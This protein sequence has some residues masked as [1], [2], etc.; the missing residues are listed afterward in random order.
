[1]ATFREWIHRLR[2]ALGRGRRDSDLEQELRLHA[3]MAAED[4][5]RRGDAP[6]AARFRTG[7]ASQAMDALRDQRGL[8][9]LDALASDIVFGWRQLNKHRT[10]S[11]AA[12]LSLGLAIGAT[13]AAF[14]LVDAVLLRPLPVTD[15]ANLF[16]VATTFV[17]SDGGSDYRD[18][19]DYPSFREYVKVAG[20][21]ADLMVVGS[22]ARQPAFFEGSGEPEIT[23]RQFLSGNVF[24][25][26]GLQPA[27][28][29]L[30]T[31]DDDRTPG[32]HPVAVLSHDFWT[33]RFGRDPA[34]LGKTF[35]A[36]NQQYE[37]VGVAAQGFTGTEPGRVAD[38]FLP[39][40]MNTEA[41]NSHGW[42]WFRMWLRPKPGVSPEQVRQ[43]LQARYS[44]FVRERLKNAPADAPKDRIDALLREEVRLLP[45]GAGASATQK[46][47]RM[48]LFIL[49]TLA[50]LLLLVACANVANLQTAQAMARRREM[51]LRVSIGAARSRL[52]QLVLMES[53]LLAVFASCVG[54]L[55]AAWSAPLIVSMLGSPDQP[56][57]L[58]LDPDWR[59]AAFGIALTVT[60]TVLFGIAPALRASA[61]K[62]IG[63]LKGDSDPHAHRRLA[64][65]LIAV[66][67]AFCVFLVFV[68]GLFMTTLNRLANKPLGFAHQRLVL[69]LLEGSTKQPAE[70]WA[71]VMDHV[72]QIPG[73]EAVALA[74]W[75]PLTGNRWRGTVRVTERMAE[76]NA[77]YFLEVTPRYFEALR[78]RIIHGRDFRAGD[79]QPRI[80]EQKQPVAGVGIVNE[81][82]ARVYFGGQNPVGRRVSVFDRGAPMEI[83]GLVSDAAYSSVREPMRPTVYVPI[84]TRTNGTLFVRTAG[85]AMSLAATLRREVPKSRPGLRVRH[86]EP[87]TALVR[88]QMVRERLLATL[89][90]FFALVALLLA[91][92]GLYG[93]LNYAV[94]RQRREIGIRMAL[95]ARAADIVK[96]VTAT[97]F[98]I[99]SLGSLVGLA[100][101]L[102]FGRVIDALL[103]QIKATD[104]LAIAAPLLTL[105][106]AAALAAL[107]P[108]LRA[109]RIDPAQTLRME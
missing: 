58:I 21:S 75:A 20:E 22:T 104:P 77:P 71:Q 50:A 35:R 4:A 11:I 41:L 27:I 16:V 109:S 102:A 30:L 61:V 93:V 100:G 97:T 19:F 36:G 86:V 40:M 105:A 1:M 18:D 92:I 80:N 57:R 39:S 94:V 82:L 8:P 52:I 64:N 44:A 9:A 72:R 48:P 28:G 26:F 74:G 76:S 87:Q 59:L 29:R 3:E 5:A 2:G 60:V 33:R 103:F 62:P 89:S 6:R 15:P 78:M 96:R 32:G 79:A 53:A 66:Q 70:A 56:V 37:I 42:S 101:G 63:A 45:A 88:Q 43:Q 73:V 23:F 95:G 46:T 84:E 69:V 83:V 65:G 90:S 108:A 38:L 55:F 25:S 85:E 54:T 106:A 47:F 81:A 107:P 34:V 12:I 10:A 7:G 14:R 68:A 13:T 98:V 17:D 31:P 51:A 91:I 49:G 99:V 24:A 67:M